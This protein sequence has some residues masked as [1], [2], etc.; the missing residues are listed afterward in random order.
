MATGSRG[1]ARD[2]DND[3]VTPSQPA[4]KNGTGHTH[5]LKHMQVYWCIYSTRRHTHTHT[6]TH[7]DAEMEG[8][9]SSNQVAV[10]L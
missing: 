4:L 8:Q 2:V 6:H 1:A 9:F 5:L 10:L 7:L 3:N